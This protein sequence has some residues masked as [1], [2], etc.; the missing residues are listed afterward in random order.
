MNTSTFQSSYQG[1]SDGAEFPS[2]SSGKSFMQVTWWA[3]NSDPTGANTLWLK[4]QANVGDHSTAIETE[5][6]RQPI[7]ISSLAPGVAVYTGGNLTL[8]GNSTIEGPSSNG[9]PV[10][11]TKVYGNFT[12]SGNCTTTT[13]PLD[14]KGTKLV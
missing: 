10:A 14:I 8:Q 6:Q 13:A 9:Q 7:G 3:P 1:G 12:G 2:A 11:S 5:V 4:A